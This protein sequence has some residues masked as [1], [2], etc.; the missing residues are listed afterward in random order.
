MS[1]SSRTVVNARLRLES[2][3]KPTAR[4]F[5]KRAF[6][7]RFVRYGLLAGNA[8]LLVAVGIFVASFSDAGSG[9]Q[10][11]PAVASA[12]SV[13]DALANPLD[14][15]SSADIAVNVARIAGL[16]EE[17]AITNQAD[18]ENAEL[19]VAQSAGGL[20]TKP[21]VVS[22]DFKSNKDI[23][24]YVVKEG[25]TAA[26]IAAKFQVTSDSIL[27]SNSLA[28]DTLN[29]GQKLVIPPTGVNG[30]VYTVKP[31]DNP[32]S[33]AEK[34][35]SSKDKIIA[36][37]DAEIGGLKVGTRII[38]PDGQIVRAV[39]APIAR[40]GGSFPWGGGPIYNGGNAYDFGYCTW[41]VAN[42]IAVPS[43][44]GN[45]NTWDNLAPRS[46]WVVG[47]APRVGSIAQTDRG[48]FGHVAVVT[49]VRETEGGTQIK[50][51]DMNGISG[52][53]NEGHSDW[54]SA[55][56]YEHYIYK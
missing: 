42:R 43:N 7:R 14:Q 54:T 39:A 10:G 50:Y 12:T 22:S 51:S 44:W 47:T 55:S 13:D 15:L 23:Q 1:S 33:L 4:L 38:I 2:N 36:Y 30:I 28:S 9:L 6:R 27:W 25:E 53:G 32:D 48:G 29:A 37:N 26:S 18:S 11:T 41:Y 8:A 56:R 16:P 40:G 3:R 21:Q 46:G 45:A 19:A 20:V 52:W 24:E 49:A 34:Y 35:R 31:G 17:R 5:H